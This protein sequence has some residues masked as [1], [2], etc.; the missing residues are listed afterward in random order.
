MTA[1]NAVRSGVVGILATLAVMGAAVSGAASAAAETPVPVPVSPATTG[2]PVRL[3]GDAVAS[4]TPTPTPTPTPSA[5]A[6]ASACG[7]ATTESGLSS[8]CAAGSD[9]SPITFTATVTA[10][11]G[12]VPT[13][14]VLFA[15][16]G[17]ILGR[18]QLVDGVATLTMSSLPAG[19][20]R[21]VA[22]Y[23]GTAQL[24]PSHTPLLIQRVGLGC[25]CTPGRQTGLIRV[26]VN[27]ATRDPAPGQRV[28]TQIVFG[29]KA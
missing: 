18:A 9:S 26:R 8:T 25:P 20:Y 14:R 5:P 21:V 3:D 23:P 2:G 19:V 6:S 15:T 1:R 13:G 16:D 7:M 29:R 28:R 27:G 12:S 11:D 22:Y 24:D 10:S 17:A 4:P